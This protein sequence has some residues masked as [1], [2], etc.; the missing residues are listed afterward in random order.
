[1]KP[2]TWILA[3]E[4][5]PDL[6]ADGIDL[7]DPELVEHKLARAFPFARSSGIRARVIEAPDPNDIRKAQ[8]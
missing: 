8:S 7:S 1:M 3:I 2:F 6:V 5:D 4:V